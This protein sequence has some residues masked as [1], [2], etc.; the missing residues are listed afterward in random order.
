MEATESA[1]VFLVDELEMSGPERSRVVVQSVSYTDGHLR[2]RILLEDGSVTTRLEVDDGGV[3]RVAD[4]D[5]MV[6]AAGLGSRNEVK[7]VVHSRRG[8]ELALK[9]QAEFVRRLYP[10]LSSGILSD[11][12]DR[13]GARAWRS[14]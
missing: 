13:A 2:C 9:S 4:L 11:L 1:F 14:Q 10:S 7:R 5:Q 8:L 6:Q 3:R 12:M